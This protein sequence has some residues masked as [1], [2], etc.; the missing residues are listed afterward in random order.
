MN[1][2]EF[3]TPVT[4]LQGRPASATGTTLQDSPLTVAR[5]E[6]KSAG[7]QQGLGL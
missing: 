4:H 6:K 3:Q 1:N 2:S 7:T 5:V